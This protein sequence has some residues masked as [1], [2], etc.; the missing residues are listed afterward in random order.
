[1]T[2]A[3]RLYRHLKEDVTTCALAPGSP[4]SENELCQRY[5]ASRTPVREACRRLSREGLI[6]IVPFRGYFITPLTLAE[7]QNLHEVQLMV[8][9]AAA[10]L[11]AQRATPAQLKAIEK[12][13]RYEYRVGQRNSYFTFLQRN[14]EL[15]VGIA[16]ASQNEHLVEIAT[17]IHTRLMRFFYLIIAMDAYGPDLVDEHEKIIAAIRGRHAAQ[18][19]ER[20]A[21][22]IRKTIARSTGMITKSIHTRFDEAGG[23]VPDARLDMVGIGPGLKPERAQPKRT[24]KTAREWSMTPTGKRPN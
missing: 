17:T 14:Y 5:R 13:G 18:A 12:A 9:P 10:A 20:A 16:E 15:H 7:F 4:V 23:D 11:A 24:M 2:T 19:S 3:D 6:T 1:M 21:E 8:E 22:H